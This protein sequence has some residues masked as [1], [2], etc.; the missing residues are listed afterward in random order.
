[1]LMYD[2]PHPGLGL[3]DDFDALGLSIAK[4][5]NALGITRQQLYK[6]VNGTSAI[7]PEMAVRLEVVIGS[8]ADHWLRL[9]NAYDLAQVRQNKA[10]LVEGLERVRVA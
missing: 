6:V 7:S 8:T 2:P 10:D 4:A 3:R 9:Q 1:M 5:A